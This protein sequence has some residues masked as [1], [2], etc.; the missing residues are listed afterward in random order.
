MLNY[1]AAYRQ[2]FLDAIQESSTDDDYDYL[3]DEWSEDPD[4]PDDK[5]EAF[6]T[7]M[8]K[9]IKQTGYEVKYLRG[10]YYQDS[11]GKID[12]SITTKISFSLIKSRTKKTYQ[13]ID[14]AYRFGWLS[15]NEPGSL[16]VRIKYD[17]ENDPERFAKDVVANIQSFG[18]GKVKHSS[19][20]DEYWN[21]F[22][23]DE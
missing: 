13:D 10:I 12:K 16:E 18:N 20:D 2:G 15:S 8:N 6:Q 14:V 22:E 1:R 23:D 11:H 4:W 19:D 7:A 21:Q 5:E 9:I 3:D 17:V